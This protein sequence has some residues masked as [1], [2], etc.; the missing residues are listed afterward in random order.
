MQ[1]AGIAEV[2]AL[3]ISIIVLVWLFFKYDRM[4]SMK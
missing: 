3:A 1:I 2:L 4:R